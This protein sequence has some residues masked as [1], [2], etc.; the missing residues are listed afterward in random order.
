MKHSNCF[1]ISS[2]SPR[3]LY[4]WW[5]RF[6]EQLSWAEIANYHGV[7]AERVHQIVFRCEYKRAASPKQFMVMLERAI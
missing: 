1:F 5:Q 7:S 3:N 6:T 2:E 4:M